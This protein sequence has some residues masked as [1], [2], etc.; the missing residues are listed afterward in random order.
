MKILST[1]RSSTN[2]RR[3]YARYRE[4]PHHQMMHRMRGKLVGVMRAILKGQGN[5][6]V[7]FLSVPSIYHFAAHIESQFSPDMT[8]DDYGRYG[9][10]THHNIPVAS[11]DLSDPK[12]ALACYHYRNLEPMWHTENLSKGSRY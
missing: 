2:T 5:P 6:S 7:A 1:S 11:F 10:H 8:W 3:W 9:W 4:D 12:Q